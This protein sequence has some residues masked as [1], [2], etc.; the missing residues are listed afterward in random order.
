MSASPRRH[1]MVHKGTDTSGAEEW[2]CRECGRH[3]VIRWRPDLERVVLDPG[4]ESAVHY[5]RKSGDVG[6]TN[7]RATP[8]PKE[9]HTLSEDDAWRHW[10]RDHG[11]DW[12]GPET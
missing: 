11:M 4:D 3:F 10:L 9:P 12:E 1:E 7:I 6:I 5:G 2:L 8:V